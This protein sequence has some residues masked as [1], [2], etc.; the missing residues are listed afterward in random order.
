MT[1][2]IPTLACPRLR[3]AVAHVEG[4]INNHSTLI[5]LDSG[6]SC[7]VISNKYI[8]V[9]QLQPAEGIQLINADGRSVLPTGTA[10]V[11][12]CLG[13]LHT[14]HSFMVLSELS[15]MVILGCDFLTK[16]N[17]VIDFSQGVAY[18]S[19]TPN[20]QLKLMHSGDTGNACRMLTLDDEFPQAIPTT[21]KNIDIPSFDMPTEVHPALKQL[22]E[23]HR[24]IFSEQLGRTFVISHAIDTGDSSPV[25]VPPR[26]IPFRYAER[27]HRQLNEMASDGIIRPSKSPW[28][29]PAVYVPKSNGELRICVDFIQLNRVTKKNSYPVPRTEGPQQKLADKHVFSKLDLR[30][31]YWQF[32]MQEQSIEKTAFC[33]GPGYGLWEFVVMLYGLT[34]ATQTCQ[35]GLDT[36]LADCKYCVD[37]YVDD[38]IIYSDDMNSHIRDL[39]EVLGRLQQAGFTL[40]GSKCAFGKSTVSHLGFQYSPSGVTPSAERIQALP[41]GQCPLVLN[42][43]NHSWGWQTFTDVLFIT[44]QKLPIPSLN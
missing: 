27:V 9:E 2:Y 34:G 12:V 14:S 39:Q 26:P 31:A 13:T 28:C 7:S 36:I 33:P 6:A 24:T 22:I 11:N 5:L 43:Y 40:R 37:N 21:M 8:S 29:A 18:S 3:S 41:T 44:L 42:N 23:S 16:H 19:T 35:Q 4:K 15:S 38:C 10:K 1:E 30:S 17:L 32:P 20:F 25:R